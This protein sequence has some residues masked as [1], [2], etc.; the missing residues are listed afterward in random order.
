LKLFE[1][2]SNL[3]LFKKKSRKTYLTD[4]GKALHENA[5]KIFEYEKEIENL[6]FRPLLRPF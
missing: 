6:I 1:D 5:Q 4:E 2:H 3:K